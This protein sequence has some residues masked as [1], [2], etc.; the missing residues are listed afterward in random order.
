MKKPLSI[1]FTFFMVI[2][3]GLPLL[4]AACGE[5]T[6]TTSPAATTA[7]ATTAGRN[8]NT[9]DTAGEPAATTI[10]QA[11]ATTAAASATTVAAAT[12]AAGAATTAASGA[13]A[14]APAASDEKARAAT[15]AAAGAAVPPNDVSRAP[16]PTQPPLDQNPLQAGAVDDNLKYQEYL[17]YLRN[18]RD[19]PALP[20]DVT[21]RYI[22]NVVDG[23]ARTVANSTVKVYS[24]Q[25]LIFEG[26][27]YSNG[28]L[29]FFPRAFA[30]VRQA[31]QFEVVAEKDGRSASRT[32]K[33]TEAGQSQNANGGGLW[34]LEM[35]GSLRPQ[36]EA[37]PNLD[38]L[39]LIDT[40]GSMGGEIRKIQATI[41]DISYQIS[42]LPGSP[43]VRY[44][45]VAYKDRGDSYVTRKFGFTGSLSE[46]SSFLNTLSASGGGDIPESLNEALHVA[47]NDMNWNK[48]E[49]VRLA[50]LVADAPPHLDYQQDYKY[51]DVTVNAMQKGIKIYPIGASGLS[52]Q[53]EYVFRQLA[54]MT[55]AQFLFITRGGD[56]GQPG[57]GGAASNTDT[58]YMEKQLD[59]LVVNIVRREITNLSQ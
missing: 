38:L 27:T 17:D 9:S 20:F 59:R 24:G 8:S 11:R 40:T 22:I 47:V 23:N 29:L 1:W 6:S 14:A 30:N 18:Y 39:F 33:R 52:K 13:S 43:K 48:A 4:L 54:Q 49:A 50:F 16:R 28:Q 53:G 36:L 32:F 26:K 12:T 55:L 19:R 51:T 58:V 2:F 44:G 46:F 57:S 41:S 15:T 10:P 35:T 21:E 37:T 25:S 31:S 56:E 45:A 42:T 3:L 7:A 34:T 5:A